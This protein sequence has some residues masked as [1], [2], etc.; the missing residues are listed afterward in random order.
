LNGWD[1]Q[2]Q[3]VDPAVLYGE[4]RQTKDGRG[5]DKAM[6]HSG[7]TRAEGI[8]S[9]KGRNA[10][11]SVL[12]RR[13]ELVPEFWAQRPLPSQ[14]QQTIQQQPEGVPLTHAVVEDRKHFVG[15]SFA[16][17]RRMQT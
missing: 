7:S 13:G 2:V 5:Q 1:V 15:E 4:T 8:E 3:N 17:G 16:E 14:R 10:I 12:L 6:D 9:R 11:P